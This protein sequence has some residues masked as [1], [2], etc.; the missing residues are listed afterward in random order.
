VRCDVVGPSC[1]IETIKNLKVIY[2]IMR[3][4]LWLSKLASAPFLS[5]VLLMI[6]INNSIIVLFSLF[7]TLRDWES[8]RPVG[9][10]KQR[11]PIC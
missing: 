9:K 4:E 8:K 11:H 7:T 3:S 1:A 5:V 6:F 10:C 2:E